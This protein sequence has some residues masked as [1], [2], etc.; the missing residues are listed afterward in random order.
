MEASHVSRLAPELRNRIYEYVL[1]DPYGAH[2]IDE[3]RPSITRICRAIRHETLLL[4]YAVNDYQIYIKLGEA[5]AMATRLS[6]MGLRRLGA[7]NSLTLCCATRA[8]D[9][10]PNGLYEGDPEKWDVLRRVLLKSGIQC[11]KVKW[12]TFTSVFTRSLFW[13]DQF[14]HNQQ[15]Q[16]FQEWLETEWQAWCDAAGKP[17]VPAKKRLTL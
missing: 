11:R 15:I 17:P 4:S 9:T 5:T 7:V 13:H 6:A 16:A 10:A 1:H 12:T 14:A 3:P 8:P 2:K